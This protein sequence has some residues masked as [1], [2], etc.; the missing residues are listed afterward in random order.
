[1]LL[2][3]EILRFPDEVTSLSDVDKG[4]LNIR[5]FHNDKFFFDREDDE[6]NNNVNNNNISVNQSSVNNNN[7]NTLRQCKPQ[8]P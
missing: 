8:R 2:G 3:P 1:M 4:D 6:K 7:V 5:E